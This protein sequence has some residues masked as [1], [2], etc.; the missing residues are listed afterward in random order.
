MKEADIDNIYSEHSNLYIDIRNKILPK[1][2]NSIVNS[3]SILQKQAYDLLSESTANLS[4]YTDLMKTLD[5]KNSMISNLMKT[6]EEKDILLKSQEYELI[7]LRSPNSN[8]HDPNFIN[9][10]FPCTALSSN[11]SIRNDDNI[12]IIPIVNN[13]I[14]EPNVQPNVQQ[15]TRQDTEYDYD[16]KKIERQYFNSQDI[17]N[18]K[19]RDTGDS[20]FDD[21]ED[22][23]LVINE[24]KMSDGIRY[25]QQIITEK[26]LISEYILKRRENYD[27]EENVPD[28]Y[29]IYIPNGIIGHPMNRNGL[30]KLKIERSELVNYGI[31]NPNNIKKVIPKNTSTTSRSDLRSLSQRD[32]IPM[33]TNSTSRSDLGSLSQRDPIPILQQNNSN[34]SGTNNISQSVNAPINIPNP[35]T[36]PNN[37]LSTTPNRPTPENTFKKGTG[38][39]TANKNLSE[40]EAT[41]K[42]L[43]KQKSY[44]AGEMKKFEVG[45]EKYNKYLSKKIEL[46]QQIKNIRNKNS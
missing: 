24:E 35:H 18:F 40:E 8:I 37:N 39:K 12:P 5:E 9:N 14:H 13:E 23:V 2:Y 27:P 19:S 26:G 11:L 21:D 17:K 16:S 6:L 10:F 42:R 4:S 1:Q 34:M 32:P 30:K 29:S 15:E 20:I 45:S 44:Y 33:N 3:L 28:K 41:A 38:K 22:I 7:R 25:T 31:K 46:E 43:V 36:P